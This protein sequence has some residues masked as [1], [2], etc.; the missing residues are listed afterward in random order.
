MA[1]HDMLPC[2][3]GD[4]RKGVVG[5]ESQPEAPTYIKTDQA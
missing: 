3:L 5:F 1:R 2:S 4:P